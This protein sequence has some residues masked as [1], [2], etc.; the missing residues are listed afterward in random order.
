M[1]YIL[2]V[3]LTLS[4]Y[5]FDYQLKPVKVANDVYCFFGKLENINKANGG[6]M[7]NTCFVA[8][9]EGFVVI[10]SGPTYEYASQVFDQM[11]KIAKLPVKY[12]ISTHE[13]DD[14]WLGNSFYKSKGA[15]IVGPKAYDENVVVG[16]ETRM[17]RV[18]GKE[19]YGKTS[20]V[21]LDTVVD[22]NLTLTLGDKHFVIKQ[23]VKHAHTEGDLVIHLEEERV[24]FAGDVV[25]NGRVTSIRDG[26]IIGSLKVLDYIDALKPKVIVGGH[27]SKTDVNATASLRNYLTDMKKE[28]LEMI[29]NDVSIHEITE[30]VI[31]PK[32]KEMKLYDVLHKSNVEHAYE[33]LEMYD[34]DDE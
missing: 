31:M 32:Y 13:H 29:E 4:S 1:K 20:I 34:A 26:S 6:N 33:E 24:V 18:L 5:G 12:V 22:D 28:I 25:F 23:F 14:H 11:Q 8:T 3:L 16:M 17:Q 27:G 2:I 21:K 15:S 9:K 30:K 10:D 7:V 19:L